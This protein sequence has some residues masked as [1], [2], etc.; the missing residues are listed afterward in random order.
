MRDW[1]ILK[2]KRGAAE[3]ELASMRLEGSVG[4]EGM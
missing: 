1:T 4:E 3:G 2:E